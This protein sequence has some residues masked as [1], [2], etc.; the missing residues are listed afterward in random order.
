MKLFPPRESLVSNIPSEDGNIEKLFYGVCI[1]NHLIWGE[2]ERIILP[3]VA[4]TYTKKPPPWVYW[5]I[6]PTPT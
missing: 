4:R 2:E 3:T 5:G 6:K 1:V